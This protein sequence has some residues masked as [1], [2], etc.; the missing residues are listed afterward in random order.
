MTLHGN[1]HGITA[2][3]CG[4]NV[5]I[6]FVQFDGSSHIHSTLV[7]YVIISNKIRINYLK[8]IKYD[9]RSEC[10]SGYEKVER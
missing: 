3:E 4:E 9:D 5:L 6:H 1:I 10:D 8:G 2:L 7:S